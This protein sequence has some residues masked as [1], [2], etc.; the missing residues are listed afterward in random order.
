MIQKF[1]YPGYELDEN[2]ERFKLMLAWAD[3]D[4]AHRRH[5]DVVK[6]IGT[7]VLVAMANANVH[8]DSHAEVCKELLHRHAP[9]MN[10]AFDTIDQAV[11]GVVGLHA[12]WSDVDEDTEDRVEYRGWIVGGSVSR[13]PGDLVRG[14][15]VS[16]RISENLLLDS[17]RTVDM[18][19]MR[20]IKITRG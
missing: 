3:Y 8:D 20:E 11:E 15:V 16:L 14:S 4:A 1:E 6:Q 17:G 2:D 12:K 7:E 9:G 18:A 5:A 10:D 19:S 13:A